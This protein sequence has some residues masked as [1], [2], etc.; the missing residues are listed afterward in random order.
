MN[1]LVNFSELEVFKKLSE[2]KRM[3]VKD[4]LID[5]LFRLKDKHPFSMD[6]LI[7]IK[8]KILLNSLVTQKTKAQWISLIG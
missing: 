1:F 2:G 6:L 5:F 8:T 7:F 3:E 4:I